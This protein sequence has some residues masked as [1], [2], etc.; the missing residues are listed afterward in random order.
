MFGE[1]NLVKFKMYIGTAVML[2]HCCPVFHFYQFLT[3]TTNIFGKTYHKSE[4]QVS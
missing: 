1:K 4:L 3:D 2:R